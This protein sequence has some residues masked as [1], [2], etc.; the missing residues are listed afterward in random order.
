MTQA[1]LCTMTRTGTEAI[2][3]LGELSRPHHVAL[4]RGTVR[5]HRPA[6]APTWLG[7][8]SGMSTPSIETSTT[9]SFSDR[10]SGW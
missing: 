4:L 7:Y 2:R 6:I 5:A 3:R 1:S 8:T 9:G 10:D